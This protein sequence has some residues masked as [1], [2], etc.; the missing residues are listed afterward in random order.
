M[1]APVHASTPLHRP[2]HRNTK[3]PGDAKEAKDA[4]V[5]DAALDAADVGGVKL[6]E[7]PELFLGELPLFALAAE[8][9]A[10]S[11]QRWMTMHYDS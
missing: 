4:G 11:F 9:S 8:I 7:L 3:R 5:A 10:Q 1:P 2:R 6:G